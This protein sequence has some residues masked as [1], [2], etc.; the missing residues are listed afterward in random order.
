M[1]RFFIDEINKSENYIKLRVDEKIYSKETIFAAG[2]IFL[3]KAFIVVD[4]DK[5]DVLV[6]LFP[7][8]DKQDLRKLAL[9]FTAELLN[10]AHYFNSARINAEAVKA[11]LQRALFSVSPPV[12]KENKDKELEELIKELEKEERA[13]KR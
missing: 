1:R 3:D 13:N 9:E 6:Y 10:Y 8:N 5:Q 12:V 2:Y 4:K 7:K 11:I